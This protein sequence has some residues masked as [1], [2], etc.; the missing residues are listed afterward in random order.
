MWHY[1]YTMNNEILWYISPLN[2]TMHS[3]NYR[4]C[5]AC[6]YRK[7]N[8]YKSFEERQLLLNRPEKLDSF[9]SKHDHMCPGCRTVS[10]MSFS[11]FVITV[12]LVGST[13]IRFGV[14]DEA[15]AGHIWHKRENVML[16]YGI[17]DLNCCE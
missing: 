15:Y 16:F 2:H 5:I 9:I 4:P 8:L 3:C 17:C 12:E 10:V 11:C 6:S 14:W 1:V 13:V 7:L